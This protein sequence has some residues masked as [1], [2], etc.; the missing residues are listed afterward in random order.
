MLQ[1]FTLPLYSEAKATEDWQDCEQITK[2]ALEKLIPILQKNDFTNLESTLATIQGT[3]GENEFTQRMRILRALIEKKSTGALIADYLAKNYHEVLVMR[4]DY[5][6]EQEYRSIYQ[7][8]KADFNYIPLRHPIDSL[9]KLKATALLNSTSYNLTE[10]EEDI[11][12]LFADHIDEFYQAYEEPAPKQ[13]P[14]A[15]AAPVYY[16]DRSGITLYAGV[17]FP[18]TGSSPVFKASPVFGVM[19]SSKLSSPF[20]YELGA[21]IRVNSN[22]RDFEYLLYDAVEVVNSSASLALGGSVGYKLL[23]AGSFILYPK[24]GLFWE[25]TGTGLT[26]TTGYYEDPYYYDGGGNVRFHNVNTMRTSLALSIMRH[27]SMKKYIGLELAYHYIPYNW[28]NNL[29]TSIQPNY[30]SAQLFFRF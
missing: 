28:D 16:E 2:I 13:P 4:W 22:D 15:S 5:A 30:A 29:L 11:A 17:E 12:F 19:Y 3:C 24:V 7:N 10:Q 26:E 9:V 1:A 18:I 14:R 8:N 6:L 21:K 20:L 27:L 23:D 25:T